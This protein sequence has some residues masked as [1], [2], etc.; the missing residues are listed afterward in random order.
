MV[1]QPL[2]LAAEP[3]PLVDSN[4]LKDYGR[5]E[6][7]VLGQTTH[8]AQ[9]ACGRGLGNQHNYRTDIDDERRRTNNVSKK[10]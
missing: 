8:V 3:M 9:A 7:T 5:D 10:S 6:W 4:G 1:A 2:K